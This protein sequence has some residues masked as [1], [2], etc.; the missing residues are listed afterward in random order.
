MAALFGKYVMV[1]DDVKANARLPDG[2]LKTISEAKVV[3]AERK[4]GP[5][6]NFVVRAVPV[7]LCNNVPSLADLSNG[8]MRRLMVIPFERTFD[9]DQDQGLFDRIWRNELPGV[10]NRS[11][12]DTVG[13]LKRDSRFKVPAAVANGDSAMGPTSESCQRFCRG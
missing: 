7:L 2:P 12:G 8:M 9:K 10:L 1:D 5:H 11:L 6:F 13:F 3:T 4:S